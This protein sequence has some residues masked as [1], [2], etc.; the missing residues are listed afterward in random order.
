MGQVDPNTPCDHACPGPYGTMLEYAAA[1]DNVETVKILL[2]HGALVSDSMK[3]QVAPRIDNVATCIANR[4]EDDCSRDDPVAHV[5]YE[6]SRGLGF[7]GG[8]GRNAGEVEEEDPEDEDDWMEYEI[9][10]G[11]TWEEE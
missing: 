10:V 5:F 9:G 4:P 1:I 2:G 11:D 8:I 7:G 6:W 3:V